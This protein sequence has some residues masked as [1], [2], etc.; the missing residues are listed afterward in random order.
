MILSPVSSVVV[1][2]PAHDEQDHVVATL[3]SIERSAAAQPLPVTGVLVLD[4]CGDETGRVA[5]THIASAAMR[6]A[7]VGTDAARASTARQRGLDRVIADHSHLPS[8]VSVAILSTDADTTVPADWIAT[9][10]RI[11]D[12]GFHGVAGVVDLAAGA[13]LDIDAW[14]REYTSGFGPN[15]SHPHVHGANLSVRLDA[16]TVAGGFGHAARA[17]DIELWRRLGSTPAVR[18]RSDTSSTVTTSHRRDGRVEGG[19]ATALEQF[20]TTSVEP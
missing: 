1:I 11:L 20:R 12:D 17:E 14:S 2:V 16:L 18:L 9:H 15:S 7:V 13:D 8:L 19:F 6:W 4:S 10:V 5:R 3:R